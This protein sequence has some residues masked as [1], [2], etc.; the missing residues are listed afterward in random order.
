[1]H[2]PDHMLTDPTSVATGAVACATLAYAA[3]RS[4]A[5]LDRR[6]VALTAATGALVDGLVVSESPP[7]ADP[8]CSSSSR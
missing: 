7:G 1:M 8:R 5:D 3:Y 6:T 2:V 4:R